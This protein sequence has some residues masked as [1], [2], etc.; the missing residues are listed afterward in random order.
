MATTAAIAGCSGSGN[1]GGIGGGLSVDNVDSQTTS[2]GNIVLTVSVSN[3]SDSSKSNTLMGQVDI[4][5][6]DTYTNR[7]DITVSGDS[8][9]TFELEFDID[10][11]ESLS[12]SE[13]EYNAQLEG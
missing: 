2:F 7:R 9:N 3:S 12:T 8:S 10:F 13:Y 11:S 1:G 4:S 5:G 6:G